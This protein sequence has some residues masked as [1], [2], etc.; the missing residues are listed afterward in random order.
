MRGTLSALGSKQRITPKGEPALFFPFGPQA[1]NGLVLESPNIQ[2]DLR[3]ERLQPFLTGQNNVYAYLQVGGV[4]SYLVVA[5]QPNGLVHF[6]RDRASLAT[7][8]AISLDTVGKL[9]FFADLQDQLWPLVDASR[10]VALAEHTLLRY[11][12]RTASQPS[13]RSALPVAHLIEQYQGL[14]PIKQVA[15]RMRL[16]PRRLEQLFATEVGLSPKNYSRVL[17]FRAVLRQLYYEPSPDWMRLVAQ[18]HYTD[19]SH[20]IRDFHRFI[21]TSP[22]QLQREWADLDQLIYKSAFS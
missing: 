14:L 11:F 6:L 12:S 3:H 22:G 15:D 7:N 5:L 1:S 20:L 16:S 13:A 21:G 8:S 19:Q 2:T 17:R 10:A 18:F 4:I 9:K